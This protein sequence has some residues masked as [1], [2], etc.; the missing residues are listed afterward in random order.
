MSAR[1]PR[2]PSFGEQ[3]MREALRRLSKR[4]T[5]PKPH[6]PEPQ[7]DWQQSMDDRL[8]AVERQLTTQNRLLVVSIVTVLFDLVV[9]FGSQVLP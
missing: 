7:D 9:K 4:L 8:T 2:R 5:P 1:T 3:R 6:R